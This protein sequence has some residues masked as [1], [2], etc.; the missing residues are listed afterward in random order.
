MYVLKK[1]LSALF[2]AIL[3]LVALTFV[4]APIPLRAQTVLNIEEK[5]KD[6]DSVGWAGDA[7]IGF[8]YTKFRQVQTSFFANAHV[9]HRN[10]RHWYL[11]L[12][13]VRF[14]RAAEENFVNDGVIHFRYNYNLKRFLEWE[15]FAQIQFNKILDVE[16]RFLTGTGP[17]FT[18]FDSEKF[19]LLLGTLYMFEYEE[20]SEPSGI[21]R[22]HRLASYMSL[23]WQ[24]SGSG[25]FE[26]TV[27]Y[28]PR[29]DKWSDYRLSG[30][31]EIK[32]DISEKFVF[33]TNFS[34]LDDSFPA[35]DSPRDVYT[36]T[37]G[38]RVNL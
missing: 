15:A 19:R 12:G 14:I 5:R 21:E 1:S 30:N 32:I 27:Y 29:L 11:L 3:F 4:V 37:N 23:V 8:I 25:S 9:Q 17:R 6:L 33:F 10:L 22:N 31:G 13:N 16:D 28:Q 24:F 2:K 36:V 38:L 18:V 7:S 35:G 20:Q 34:Y 26:T